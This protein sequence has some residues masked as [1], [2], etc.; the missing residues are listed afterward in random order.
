M[1]PETTLPPATP[2][3]PDNFISVTTDRQS[4]M[5]GYVD[6][7]KFAGRP[8]FSATDITLSEEESVDLIFRVINEHVGDSSCIAVYQLWLYENDTVYIPEKLLSFMITVTD[9]IND[10]EEYAILYIND[11]LEVTKLPCEM[12][13][14]ILSFNNAN[15]GYFALIGNRKI[16]EPENTPDVPVATHVP[17]ENKD[18]VSPGTFVISL[19]ITAFIALW[20][21]VGIGFVIW[22]KNK[23]KTRYSSRKTGGWY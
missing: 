14:N 13:N 7:D 3:I 23:K 10:Y 9:E 19:I 20:I 16:S 5:V 2:S 22:G 21:G 18:G 4:F 6:G 15:A 1:T 17:S 12:K 11:N 8:V